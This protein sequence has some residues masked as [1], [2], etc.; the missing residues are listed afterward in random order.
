MSR[1]PLH[2]LQGFV[3]AV[4]LGNLSRAAGAMHLT[5]S[6]LSHQM[7]AL[8]QR[9]GYPLL[10]RHARGVTATPQASNCSTASHRIWTP[11]LRH[12][13]HS[14]RVAKTP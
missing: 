13:S 12:S 14:V 9:L 11:S 7:R 6:A 4:R 3:S 10:Q 5:V 2:A 8:E 1:P